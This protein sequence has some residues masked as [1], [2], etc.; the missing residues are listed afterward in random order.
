MSPEETR[1]I[2]EFVYAT[3]GTEP[4]ERTFAA[5]HLVIGN[6]SFDTARQSAIMA[7]QDEAIT[8]LEPKH[9]LAKATKMKEAAEAEQRKQKAIAF[10][11]SEKGAEMPLCAHGKGLLYCDPCCHQSAIKAGLV[12]NKPYK[13][14]IRL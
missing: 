12:E 6:L 7:M 3:K 9:L 2:V 4:T 1:Q 5:W 10:Q 11:A 13:Q 14:K 8:Y